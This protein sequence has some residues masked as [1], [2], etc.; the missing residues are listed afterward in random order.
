M[1][2]VVV[3]T[4]TPDELRYVLAHENAHVAHADVMKLTALPGW[5]FNP[6]QLEFHGHFNF[7]KAGIV[8]ADALTTV[9]P[10]YAR[11][12]QT[13]EFGCGLEGRL[14]CPGCVQKRLRPVPAR[15]YKCRKA[16]RPGT[17]A[18]TS[19]NSG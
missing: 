11:E 7:L 4:V 3:N 15:C 12:I 5:L 14:V 10:T 19:P 8:F 2:D 17:Q 1:S 9:S 18:P 6:N 13:H 16:T